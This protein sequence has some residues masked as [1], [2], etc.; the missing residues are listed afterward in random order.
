MS[1]STTVVTGS[2][3]GMGAAIACRLA[4]SGQRVIG[5]DLR[6]ADVTADLSTTG[7]RELAI[8]AINK[9]CEG[10]LDR[11]VCCAGLGPSAPA[12]KI[13]AVNFFGVVDLLDALKP[14]LAAGVEP[15]VVVIGSNEASLW[16]WK[17]NPLPD[18]FLD[19]GEARVRE[20]LA[21]QPEERASHVAYAGSKQ[22]VTVAARRRALEW[23]RAGIRLNVVAPGAVQTPLLQA[24]ESD[25]RF[26]TAVK[27]FVPPLGRRADPDEIA[28]MVEFLLS[29]RSG[30]VHGS[31]IYVDGGI[32]ASFRPGRF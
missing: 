19:E 22:A 31:V 3:S 32:D 7:G 8:S 16:D 10:R 12:G 21:E 27:E 14:A 26:A 24:C 9:K 5:V 11:L 28:A 13:A 23:G 2:A 15:S 29:P 4:A 20:L 17:G 18:A 1:I 6:D 25:P 30:Y